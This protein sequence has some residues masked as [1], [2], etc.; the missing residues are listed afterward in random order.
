MSYSYTAANTA[1]DLDSLVV[2]TK[3]ATVY[4][5]QEQS[6]FLGGA[7]VPVVNLP[8]GS[9]TAQIPVM[10]TITATKLSNGSHTE[11]DISVT[12]VGDTKVSILANIYAA[13][14]VLR[15]LGAVDPAE[16]G[17]VLGNAVVKKF[18]IDVMTAFAGGFTASADTGTLGVDDIFDAVATIRGSG[19]MGQLYGIISPAAANE[20]M[21]ALYNSNAYV[22][23]GDFQT[24]ALRNGFLG[25]IAGVRMFQSAYATASATGTTGF[26]GAIFG[27]D[28]ARV[29][30]FKN[31]D[32]EVQRRAAAVGNDIVA[33][34]HA[35]VGV[36]DAT[37]GIALIDAA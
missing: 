31:V 36:V 37:R 14:D 28:A 7:L 10:G 22:A 8:A 27:A 30:M 35:G 4:T 13:R 3:A 6:L 21:K 23:G 33:S 2:A 34:L 20:L 18:D 17:R 32:L 15:D 11:P 1:Y 9:I 16:L 19:E 12:N 26:K 24:E 5:A 29:A 25:T